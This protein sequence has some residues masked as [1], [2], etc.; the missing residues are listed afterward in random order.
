[1][2]NAITWREIC[3]QRYWCDSESAL[4]QS[5]TLM[6]CVEGDDIYYAHEGHIVTR[7]WKKHPTRRGR[8]TARS[9]MLRS[10]NTGALVPMVGG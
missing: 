5:T 7:S 2:S 6:L 8:M 9:A 3:A 4:W 10:V 1:M